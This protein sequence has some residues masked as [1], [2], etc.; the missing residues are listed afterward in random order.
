MNLESLKGLRGGLYARK[1]AYRGKTKS[2]GRS[3]R[4]Q[5]DAGQ[6][7]ADRFGV[8]IVKEFVDDDRSASIYRAR[9]RE[10]FESMI[11]WIN[12][13]R[14][15]IVFAWASTRLQRDLAVYARLRDACAAN[16]VLWCY[17]GKVYDLT[18]K[19]DRLQ[20][21]LHALLGEN[22][23]EEMRNNV[24]RTLRANAANGRPHGQEGYGYRRVYDPRTRALLKI[25]VEPAEAK[26]IGELCKRVAAGDAYSVIARDFNLRGVA[27][28]A[29]QWRKEHIGRLAV[30]RDDLPENVLIHPEWVQRIKDHAHLQA[31]VQQRL[32]EGEEELSVSQDFNE[33]QEPL[34]LARWHAA[35]IVDY[36]S[37][38]RYIGVR[39]H[40]GKATA[41]GVWPKIVKKS[42]HA[43][44]LAIIKERKRK[45]HN[46]RPGR[47]VNWLSGS[48]VCDV[49]SVAVGSG[50]NASGPYY[51]CM[52]PKV[53]GK[54]GGKGY[55]VSATTG[56]IDEFVEEKLFEWLSSPQFVEAYTKG[57]DEL[58]KQ[59]AEADAE[60]TL[61]RGRLQEFRESA[62]DG[63]TSAETLA[64]VEAGLL[65]KIEEAEKVA[66]S[67]KAPSLVR[68]LVAATPEE[69]ATAWAEVPMAQ[70][71]LVAETLLDIRLRK[72]PRGGHMPVEDHVVVTPRL[73]AAA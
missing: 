21:G 48:M 55:H 70:R 64:V 39:T 17:G 15:D 8:P 3:V 30:W 28:P 47:A 61:L 71:R 19:D 65:P 51:R 13:K 58:M 57:D 5:L 6:A 29:R 23:V 68:D 10:E 2:Q 1:S 20:T 27:P 31:E 60:V 50:R 66:K 53:E 73:P 16:G 26:I 54:Y 25:E 46:S 56:P 36:A 41:E 24:L 43:R 52:Q 44:C 12:K 18:N 7:D 34:L 22:E 32:K 37:H 11:E 9:E 40:H 42:T 67:L 4:E 63:K 69:V 62:I 72:A 14:L 35:T 45:P 59:A 33:R 38:P 49:C